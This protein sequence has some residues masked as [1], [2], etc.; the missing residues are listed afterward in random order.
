MSETI[1]KTVERLLQE[2][3]IIK[4][5]KP[6]AKR[7]KIGIEIWD[8]NCDAIVSKLQ[9]IQKIYEFDPGKASNDF[10]SLEIAGYES[11]GKYIIDKN[12]A[13]AGCKF[14]T[15]A[16]QT[17]KKKCCPDCLSTRFEY[18]NTNGIYI[19]SVCKR[20]VGKKQTN[21]PITKD[22]NNEAKHITKQI[23]IVTGTLNTPP[24]Q[25][26]KILP[27]INEWFI[28]RTHIYE[29]L[30]FSNRYQLFIEKYK[31][32]MNTIID[33]TFFK[34][35]IK[36]G[37]KNLCPYAEFKMFCDEFYMLTERIKNYE[38]YKSNVHYLTP[39]QQIQ[40]CQYYISIYGQKLPA[41]DFIFEINEQK[42][43]LG[44]YLVFWKT[45]DIHFENPIHQ[46]LNQ[47]FNQNIILPGLIFEFNNIKGQKG[48]ILQKY[49]YQQ[50]YMF[51]IKDVYKIEPIEIIPRDKSKIIEIM[52]DF[53]NFVKQLKSTEENK[54]HN[55]CLWQ[56]VLMLVLK[57]PYYRCYS[58]IIPIL[59]I[60]SIMTTLEI[61]EHWAFYR[62]LKKE[63]LKPY[64]TT[65]RTKIDKSATAKT[66]ICDSE[67]NINNVIDFI[68]GKGKYFGADKEDKYLEDKLHIQKQKH[69]CSP[70][71][72]ERMK[73]MDINRKLNE[74]SELSETNDVNNDDFETENS[75]DFENSE[76][77]NS[78]TENSE[79]NFEDT[80]ETNYSDDDW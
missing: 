62:L 7:G 61:Q 79:N 35:T 34:Q 68:S 45:H 49:N 53:N 36:P 55:A 38:A 24:A 63:Y 5:K 39:E 27:Y 28:N 1:I 40:L 66:I 14:G 69:E 44:T 70:E 58:S 46:Q 65:L 57:M 17:K 51:I 15:T 77:E 52:I 10:R 64:L 2:A 42:F 30:I 16:K 19:C 21:Q 76:T 23:N 71:L 74:S 13:A 25:V 29:W 8:T 78:E 4:N 20:N 31:E 59:P 67:V 54:K 41:D 73:E 48:K 12:P 80:S 56:V 72:I 6:T 22:T 9:Q 43:Q 3:E 47:I 33:E 26:N 32:E 18:D 11:F 37:V 50:N 60:K 75:E